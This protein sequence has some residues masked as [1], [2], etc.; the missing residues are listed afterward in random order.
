MYPVGRNVCYLM[1]LYTQGEVACQVQLDISKSTNYLHNADS[2]VRIT[3]IQPQSMAVSPAYQL[4][5]YTPH[6]KT[7]LFHQKL[8]DDYIPSFK[9]E[10]CLR[11]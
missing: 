4:N 10:C 5:N 11:G 6:R 9:E 2:A 8:N 7:R 1:Y 3:Q